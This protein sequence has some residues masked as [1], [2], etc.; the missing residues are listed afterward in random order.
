VRSRLS[1][2]VRHLGLPSFDAYL[3][4]V[5]ADPQGGEAAAFVD[6]LTTNKTSFNREEKH[7]EYLKSAVLPRADERGGKLRI[8]S[9]GCSSG[10]EPY[11][12]AMHL[13]ERYRDLA[14]RD[15][16]IL[17]T[18]I[19]ERVLS[20]ARAGT[21]E[22][23]R[24]EGLQHDQERRHFVRR[25]ADE[26]DLLEVRPELRDAVKFARLNLMGP[27][28]MRGPFDAIFCRNVMIYFDRE[29]REDLVRRF[30]SLLVPGGTLF[31]GHSESLDAAKVGLTYVQPSVYEK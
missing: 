10:E 25:R 18:D 14:A 29:T 5:A 6:L 22:A 23:A 26:A 7:F 15:A 24:I 3:K 2:R 4:T 28:P 19:S 27:W 11:T 20:V 16:M 30:A 9:A 31:I 17:A 1:K 12:I 13:R 8:W 21:Y